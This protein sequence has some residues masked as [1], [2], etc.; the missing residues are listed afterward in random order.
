MRN[1]LAESSIL[2][3]LDVS[4]I[5]ITVK[6]VIIITVKYNVYFCRNF[7]ANVFNKEIHISCFTCLQFR[8]KEYLTNELPAFS[9]HLFF[10]LKN[11]INMFTH[12]REC[13]STYNILI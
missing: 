2:F 3:Q 7:A 10:Y 1:A 9:R 13:E 12:L 5:I 4:I 11:L 6:S 8:N